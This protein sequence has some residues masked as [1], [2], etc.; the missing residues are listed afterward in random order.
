M[1][2]SSAS[3][4][5][6]NERRNDFRFHSAEPDFGLVIRTLGFRDVLTN[7]RG[8]GSANVPMGISRR[9]AGCAPDRHEGTAGFPVAV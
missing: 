7:K 2:T 8:D 4:A 9:I 3:S 1:G 6:S 5:V